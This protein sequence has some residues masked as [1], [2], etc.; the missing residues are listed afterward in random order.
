[1]KRISKLFKALSILFKKPYLLNLVINS[2]EVYKDDLLKKHKYKKGLPILDFKTFLSSNK[3]EVTPYAFLD[4]GSLP[5]DLAL[6]KLL[7]QKYKVNDYLEI[8]TW[9]GE[10]VA[11]IAS[12]VPNCYTVNL[13]FDEMKEMDLEENYIK[14]HRF[15]SDHLANVKH[16]QADSQTYDFNVLNTKFDMIFIDGDHHYKSIKKDTETAFSLLKNKNSIIVWHDYAYS[17][18]SIRWEVLMGIL[19]GCPPDK[20]KNIFHISNTLCA[21]YINEN[22]VAN[23]L[24][25]YKKPTKN[26][27]I[28]LEVEDIE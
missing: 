8:G 22:F 27:K 7:A 12:I 20:R 15:F 16:I 2:N 26:F 10:S 5:S 25:P 3:V 24:E 11:N 17:P 14:M 18:E 9:R 28:T 1:M 4:G 23:F 6:L 19:D 13:P 21:V